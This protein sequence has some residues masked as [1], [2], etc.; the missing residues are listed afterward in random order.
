MDI[1]AKQGKDTTGYSQPS[2]A[3]QGINLRKTQSK[4]QVVK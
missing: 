2:T 3:H 1:Y 4:T